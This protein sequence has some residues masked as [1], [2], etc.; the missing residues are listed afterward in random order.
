MRPVYVLGD[1]Q[2]G[3][4]LNEAGRRLGVFVQPMS[5]EQSIDIPNDALITAER[6]HWSENPFITSVINHTGWLNA[7]ALREIPDR[8]RQKTLLDELGLPTSKWLT[9]NA[10]TQLEE[11]KSHLGN[12]FLL[13][14]ARDGY[15]GKGQWRFTGQAEAELPQWKDAA[16]AEQFIDFDTEVSI[17]GARNEQGQ[18]A[19][20]ELTENFHSDGILQIS[21]K[22]TGVFSQ[23]QAEAEAGLSKIMEKLD[24]VGVMAVEFFVTPT[25][26]LI[27]EVAPRVHNSGHWTQ[28]GASISQ[29]ELHLRGVCNLPFPEIDQSGCSVMVNL[30]GEPFNDQWHKATGARI[31]WYGKEVRAARKLGHINF[32]HNDTKVMASW[33]QGLSLDARYNS[34]RAKVLERLAHDS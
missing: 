8:R 20:Y 9:T 11:L 31:H 10:D 29:F 1:G 13:K 16:I 24:Y 5:I 14:S 23:Y 3:N 4:M 26:L 25:G 18:V 12:K 2:L 32:H 27:N 30:I 6:E 33:L 22:K 28:A 19:F 7:A 15:D 34:N 21:I 17:V